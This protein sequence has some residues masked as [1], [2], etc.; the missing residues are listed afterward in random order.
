M[1][2]F[3]CGLHRVRTDMQHTRRSPNATR[4]AGHV[5]ALALALRRWPRGARVQ[6]ESATGTALRAA[7]GALLALPSLAMADNIRAVTVRTGEDLENH[8]A[9]RSR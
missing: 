1:P 7:A 5:D 4:I 2:F 6:E 8:E 3:S 9:I